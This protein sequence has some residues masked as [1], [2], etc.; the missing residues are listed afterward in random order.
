MSQTWIKK[1]EPKR[2]EEVVG[3]KS[4]IEYVTN[5]IKYFPKVSKK[6]LLLHG[7]TGTGKTCI[8]KA[9]ANQFNLELIELNASDYRNANAIATTLMPAAKQASLFG[10]QKLILIDEVDGLSG[11]QDRGGVSSVIEVI[12]ESNFP[13]ILTANDAFDDKL[14]SLRTYCTLVELKPLAT[15]DI[16]ARLNEIC[17]KEGILYEPLA[18]QMLAATA[19]GDLRAAIN[20]LQML[21][22]KNKELKREEL[23]LWSREQ[24]EA[25][26]TILKLIFKSYDTKAVYR[27][28][29]YIEDDLEELMMWIDQNLPIEYVQNKDLALAYCYLAASDRFLSLIKRRQHWRLFVYARYLALVGVQQAKSETSKRFIVYQ[30]P[31]LLLKFFIMAAKRKK[32]QALAQDLANIMHTSSNRLQRTFWPYYSYVANKGKKFAL[33]LDL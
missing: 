15:S 8:V 11:Q 7:P 16:L 3:Q 24:K 1:Y 6:A 5:F 33:G 22:D 20:D 27:M 32:M 26:F 13:I 12:K 29:D 2:T 19:N 18:L 23:R 21:S 30:K 4:I 17:T 14:K 9:I 10:Q 31:E 28:F 25:L